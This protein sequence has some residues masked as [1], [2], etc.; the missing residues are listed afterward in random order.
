V[1]EPAPPPAPDQV[2][3]WLCG[4]CGALLSVL[5]TGSGFFPTPGTRCGECG[6]RGQRWTL[7]HWR[8]SNHETIA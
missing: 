3:A 1:S 8:P 6:K 2:V 5:L 7:G 4:N